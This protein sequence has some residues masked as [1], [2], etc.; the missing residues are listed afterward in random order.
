MLIGKRKLHFGLIKA[1][2]HYMVEKRQECL[3]NG[4]AFF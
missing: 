3:F 1:K 2:R 4:L